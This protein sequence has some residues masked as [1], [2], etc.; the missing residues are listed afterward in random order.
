MSDKYTDPSGNTA[1]FQ[2]FVS[3]PDEPVAAK[4]TPVG[5]IVGIAALALVVVAVVAYLVLS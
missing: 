4:R 5:L 3:R 1:Q 2:A